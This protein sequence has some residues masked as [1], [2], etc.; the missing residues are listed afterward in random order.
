MK[1]KK[2]SWKTLRRFV[3]YLTAYSKDIWLA[4]LLG[5]INGIATVVMTLQIGQSI[6]Q[7]IGVGQVRFTKLFHLLL[8]FVGIVLINVVSQ[9]L[10]QVLSN[11]LAYLS[12]AKLRK[13]AFARL[14]K[15]PLRYYDQNS[16]GNIVSRFTNDMDNISIAISAAFNQLFAGVAI[17]VLSFIFMLRLSP[18][19]TLVVVCSTPIIFLVS[20]I[21][22]RASQNDF[23]N[24]QKIIGNISGFVTE[25]IG[26]QKIIKAFQQEEVNQQQFRVL[27]ADLYE[28]GQ[29][30]QFSSS[31]T[32]PSSRFIDHMAYLSIGLVGGLLALRSGSAITVGVISSFT[33]Y[34]S[35]FSKPFIELSGITTQ[36]QTAFSGLER[37]FELIDQPEETPDD[38]D[39]YAL[40]PD[41]IKGEVVFNH[42]SFSYEPKQRL[43]ENFNFKAEPGQTIAIVGKTGAGKSTLVNL[44]MRFYETTSGYITIDDYDIRHIQRDTLRKSF[45]MVLQDT[46]L[47]DSTLREN[48]QYGKPDASDEE[49]NQAL[50][51]SY[52]YE[53]VERLPEKLDTKI[54]GQG[55]KISDGQR[56]LLTIARTMISN[57][58]MLI[59]DEATSSVDTLTEKKIQNAFLA[60]MQ[61][62]TSFVIAHRLSTIKNADQILVM[63]QGAIVEMGTHDELLQKNGYYHQLYQAQFTK[64]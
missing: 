25:R 10:I 13:D 16:H 7:M 29:R 20:W 39:A 56:Q 30:A 19:L 15:L 27:N 62:K 57:P 54:G 2:I 48:L 36:I 49:I 3:P 45:G 63:D 31:L 46:W 33:I 32:N 11:R 61:G 14:N 12:V 44:L 42:V 53:F 64:Q 37:A 4:I 23:D 1:T 22:A 35:Q 8:L 9:W 59:L 24:Q 28:K 26:N 38:P 52:M 58:P 41:T 34:S 5:I 6:D 51:A 55:L 21:V 43:I 47:F 40:N 18:L 17:I 60:M 50:K